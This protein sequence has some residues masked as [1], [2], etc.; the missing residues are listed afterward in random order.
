MPM[1]LLLLRLLGQ[2]RALHRELQALL[3]RLLWPRKQVQLRRGRRRQQQIQRRRWLRP[4]CGPAS[5][6]PCWGQRQAPGPPPRPAGAV[7]Q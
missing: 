7:L 1:L 4:S 2:G 6:P 3:I 5:G